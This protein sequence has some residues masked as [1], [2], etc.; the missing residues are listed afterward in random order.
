MITW[1][2]HPD[3]KLPVSGIKLPAVGMLL[4]KY[5]HRTSNLNIV[6]QSNEIQSQSIFE[7]LNFFVYFPQSLIYTCK[8]AL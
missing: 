6:Q 2:Q 5:K 3:H 4:G 7:F 8:I 1:N